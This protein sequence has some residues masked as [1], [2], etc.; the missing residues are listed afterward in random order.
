MISVASLSVQAIGSADFTNFLPPEGFLNNFQVASEE[1]MEVAGVNGKRWRLRS[2]QFEP[3]TVETCAA[4][5]DFTQAVNLKRL[6]GLM[7]GELATLILVSGGRSY[8]GRD[9]KIK[10]VIAVPVNGELA[11]SDRSITAA[12]CVA[13]WSLEFTREGD[14]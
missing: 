13:T 8:L 6:Y 11:M 14:D 2:L 10:S 9:V 5:A 12:H 3:F 4:A 7:R 1:E